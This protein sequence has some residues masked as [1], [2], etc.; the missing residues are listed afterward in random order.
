MKSFTKAIALVTAGQMMGHG[1][2]E[3]QSIMVGAQPSHI[4]MIDGKRSEKFDVLYQETAVGSGKKY[5][6]QIKFDQPTKI[7]EMYYEGGNLDESHQPG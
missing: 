3:E 4:S 5:Q 7:M 2:A 6:L 1:R